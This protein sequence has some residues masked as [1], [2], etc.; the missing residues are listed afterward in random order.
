MVNKKVQPRYRQGD[1]YLVK[2][3]GDIP[4]AAQPITRDRGRVVLA[5]GEVT[6]HAH[7]I[8]SPEVELFATTAEAADR[9]LRVGPNGATLTHDE[10]AAIALEPGVYRVRIQREYSPEAIRRVAD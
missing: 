9:W 6:G 3:D 10:H 1:V 8:V 5:Y 2:A 7:V 4:P